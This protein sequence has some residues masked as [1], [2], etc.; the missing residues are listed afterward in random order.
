MRFQRLDLNLLV[1][2]DALL[3]ERNITRAAERLHM[4]QSATSGILGRLRTYFGDDLLVQVGRRMEP[5]LLAQRMQEPVRELLLQ[6]QRV[7]ELKTDFDPK[8]STRTFRIAASDYVVSVLFAEVLKRKVSAFPSMTIELIPLNEDTRSQLR[9]GEIDFM[10]IPE[11]FCESDLPSSP[12]FEESHVC[13]V[14]KGN[15]LVGDTLSF[16]QYMGLGHI[17]PRF[18]R[19]RQPSFEEWFLKQFGPT[20][21]I[22]VVTSDFASVAQLLIGTHLVATMHSQLALRNA[23]YLPLRVLAPPIEIPKLRECLQWHAFQESDPGHVWL[24]E[25]ITTI[26]S[27]LH[28][29]ESSA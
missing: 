14:W 8:T 17:T 13:V 12:L 9:R 1:A 29:L 26:A 27:T 10:V 19:A 23:R 15:T 22:E 2:L 4:S 25:L 5:T 28:T 11:N 18:G 24:R 21:R 6:L 16:D 7:L 20:R 3:S